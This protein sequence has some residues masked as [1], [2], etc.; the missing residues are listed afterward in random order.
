MCPSN[1]LYQQ[2]LHAAIFALVVA[3]LATLA[4]ALDLLATKFEH[5]GATEETV[6]EMRKAGIAL[7]RLDLY[8][9][10]AIALVQ[11]LL[12]LRCLAGL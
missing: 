7:F 12:A 3:A 4:L 1:L 6:A 2:L 11:I 8:F 9:V 5:L 10:L